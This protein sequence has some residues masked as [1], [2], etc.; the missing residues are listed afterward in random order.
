MNSFLL[1]TEKL[2]LLLLYSSEVVFF[3]A[4]AIVI[5]PAALYALVLAQCTTH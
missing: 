1:K 5:H 4:L 3:V 2:P